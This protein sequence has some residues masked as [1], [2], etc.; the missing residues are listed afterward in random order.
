MPR[1]LCELIAAADGAENVEIIELDDETALLRSKEL[2]DIAFVMWRDRQ[3]GTAAVMRFRGAVTREEG[4]CVVCACCRRK[5]PF[6]D[7]VFDACH[8]HGISTILMRKAC[9]METDWNYEKSPCP[10]N[11]ERFRDDDW[12]RHGEERRE[13]EIAE[14][15]IILVEA[16]EYR[17]FKSKHSQEEIDHAFRFIA[18]ME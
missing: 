4:C 9:Q 7:M 17:G 15:K 6:R 1:N 14:G 2:P 8:T 3:F 5:K 13:R 12:F 10:D 16:N 18:G 11:D